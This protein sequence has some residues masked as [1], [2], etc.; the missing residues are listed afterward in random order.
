M[1]IDPNSVCR[2]LLLL[3]GFSALFVLAAGA[4]AA[5][6]QGVFGEPEHKVVIQVSTADLQ[7]QKIALNNAMN[8]QKA[9]GRY[10]VAIEI[11]AYGPGLSI[12][13]T[14]SEYKDRVTSMAMQGIRFSACHNTMEG[15][16]R[17][18]G[19][20]PELL[21]GVEVVPSGVVRIMKLQQQGYAYIRP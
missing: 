14:K 15:I 12:L 17:R 8:L 3:A 19:Q 11:V 5:E 1:K 9:L 13:T 6:D 7:V 4:L 20:L 2:N 18:T 21:E 16:K 10:N